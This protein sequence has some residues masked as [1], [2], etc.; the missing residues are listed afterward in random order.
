MYREPLGGEMIN[1]IHRV[2]YQIRIAVVAIIV[3]MVFIFFTNPHDLP[4]LL[5][6]TPVLLLFIFLT[7]F[8]TLTFAII[9]SINTVLMGRNLIYGATIS[10]V[11]CLALMLKSIDQLNSKDILLIL[12]FSTVSIFYIRHVKST[13][14]N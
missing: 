12:L 6:L 4:I 11:I 10:F 13:T 9:N 14:K 7:S 5:L 2:K 3:L 8:L 1:I